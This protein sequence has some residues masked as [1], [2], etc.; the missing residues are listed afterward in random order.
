MNTHDHSCSTCS[1]HSHPNIPE[2]HFRPLPGTGTPVIE[3]QGVSFAYDDREVLSSVDLKV[4]SGDFMA[5][6]GPNGGG[7]TT[8]VKLILGLLAPKAGTVRVLGADP[9]SVR[10]AVGYVPQHALIQPSFPVTV[11]EVVLLGLRRKGDLFSTGRWPG[12]RARDKA[13]AMETLRMVDMAELATRRFDALSGGQKQRVLV[14]RALVSDPALLLFD[15][16]TSNIDPQ[17]KVCLFDLLS[18]LSSSITIVMVSHDLISASTRISSVAV[19]NRTLIQNQSRELT[20][21]MLELIYGTHDA[22]CPLDTYI[23]EMSSIFG[24]AGPRG[25]I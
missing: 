13:K 15:E 3:L 20:P 7:K 5:V 10:P 22:S 8:L 24:Q 6:I 14:A 4:S 18:A 19:V 21:S 25:S 16:P 2:P 1:G 12:Y 11:H 17:G 9:L 23:R